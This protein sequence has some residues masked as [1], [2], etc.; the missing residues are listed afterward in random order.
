MLK[1]S[2]LK[3][4]LT[5]LTQYLHWQTQ[6]EK[7]QIQILCVRDAFLHSHD[8][9][10]MLSL[11]LLSSSSHN[12]RLKTLKKP[13]TS[14]CT[15]IFVHNLNQCNSTGTPALC[16]S[17]I[18]QR[19]W[20]TRGA[21]VKLHVKSGAKHLCQWGGENSEQKSG[22]GTVNVWGEE[23]VL[24]NWNDFEIATTGK[25]A[26]FNRQKCRTCVESRGKR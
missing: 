4:A 6:L 3:I 11:F 23:V 18:P 9:H 21:L 2:C 15:C 1:K 7:W 25:S 5:N 16:C 13:G 12:P 26:A 24:D 17:D 14:L 22:S 10:Q 8:H 20:G 19:G